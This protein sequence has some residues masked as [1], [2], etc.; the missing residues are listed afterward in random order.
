M[1]ESPHHLQNQLWAK[2]EAAQTVTVLQN[3]LVS[4]Q[5]TESLYHQFYAWIKFKDLVNSVS[6]PNGFPL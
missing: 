2:A 5:G 4:P 3:N 6:L 1:V